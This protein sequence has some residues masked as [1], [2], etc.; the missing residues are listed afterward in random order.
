MIPLDIDIH[1][2]PVNTAKSE[3]GHWHADFRYAFWVNA[4][5]VDIQLAEVDGYAWRPRSDAP[6][7]KLAAKIANL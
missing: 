3:P 6:T 2:I 7:P 4:P 5:Q 1:A